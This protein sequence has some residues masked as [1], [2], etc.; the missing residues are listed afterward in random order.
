MYTECLFGG[1]QVK[2]F[3]IYTSFHGAFLMDKNMLSG[4]SLPLLRRGGGSVSEGKGGGGG[5][6]GGGGGG[7]G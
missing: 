6:G 5:E 2:T 4:D 1:K 3:G 7:E